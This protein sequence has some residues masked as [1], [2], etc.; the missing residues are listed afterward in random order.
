MVDT[1]ID[2]SLG[3][4]FAIFLGA[5][6]FYKFV[7]A[8]IAKDIIKNGKNIS[9]KIEV[10]IFS[11][12]SNTLKPLFE[13]EKD[14]AIAVINLWLE[15]AGEYN[16]RLVDLQGTEQYKNS[17]FDFINSNVNSIADFRYL[18]LS[19]DKCLFWKRYLR[20]SN[21]ILIALDLIAIIIEVVFKIFNVCNDNKMVVML[22]LAFAFIL[23]INCVWSLWP[24]HIHQDRIEKYEKN[25]A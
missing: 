6:S 21:Y 7:V 24:L 8:D 15:G 22:L 18:M 25:Y 20:W 13:E 2:W 12:L 5:I 10:R 4:H 3:I 1:L 17:I 11:E 16:E 14:K 9:K 23:I 19:I